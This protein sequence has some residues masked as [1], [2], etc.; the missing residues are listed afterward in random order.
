MSQGGEA[1]S[2]RSP[3]EFSSA[4][5][6]WDPQLPIGSQRIFSRVHHLGRQH[7]PGG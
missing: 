1:D 7:T 5:P 6:E 3:C 2:Q 4:D